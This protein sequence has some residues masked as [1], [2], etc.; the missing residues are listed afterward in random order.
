MFDDKSKFRVIQDHRFWYEPKAHTL[1][2]V[3]EYM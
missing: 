3:S 1:L 2:S